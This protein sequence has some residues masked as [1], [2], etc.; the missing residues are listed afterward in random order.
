MSPFRP[1]SPSAR[2]LLGLVPKRAKPLVD[3][4]LL[5]YSSYQELRVPLLPRRCSHVQPRADH[6]SARFASGA[7]TPRTRWRSLSQRDSR[8]LPRALDRRACGTSL[9]E[10]EQEYRRGEPVAETRDGR[11]SSAGAF[12]T[13]VPGDLEEEPL[14]LDAIFPSPR[15]W[16]WVAGNGF[17]R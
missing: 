14:R 17:R 7:R 12:R 10:A 15:A 5:S 2:G 8:S 4:R 11:L 9:G 1:G 6:L 3:G 13:F 16:P